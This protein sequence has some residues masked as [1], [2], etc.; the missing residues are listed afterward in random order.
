MAA[1]LFGLTVWKTRKLTLI[2]IAHEK[3]CYLLRS[4]NRLAQ[5]VDSQELEDLDKQGPPGNQTFGQV[6]DPHTRTT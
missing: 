4:E 6:A 1:T 5:T 2:F 3:T